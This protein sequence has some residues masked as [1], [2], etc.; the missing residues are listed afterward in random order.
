RRAEDRKG[1][2][3]GTRVDGGS[4][5]AATEGSVTMKCL[6]GTPLQERLDFHSEPEPT[7]GC[8]LWIGYRMPNGYG[9]SMVVGE[10]K[11]PQLVHR[12]AWECHHGQPIP[13]G[14]HIDH[15][16]RNRACINPRHLEVVTK[17]END[18][19]GMSIMAQNL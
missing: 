17:Y 19:R 4:A 2:Q 15:L 13:D 11:R 12:M 6:P 8:V 7:S 10:K 14:L 1:T 9:T 16:C 18:R 5:T 3:G